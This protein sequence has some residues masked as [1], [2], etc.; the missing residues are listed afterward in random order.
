MKISC[1]IPAYNEGPRIKGVLDVVH[2]HPLVD[3]VVVVDD[4]SKDTTREIVRS[5]PRV[6]LISHSKNQG[7]SRAVMTG[8]K[9]ASHEYL[10]FL[11]A[12]LLGLDKQAV[13]K[14]IEDVASNRA[15]IAISLRANAPLPWRLIGLDYISGERVFPK[16]LITPHLEEVANLPPFGL[17]SF[18][19]NLIIKN[20]YRVKVVEWSQ[21]HSPYKYK[22]SGFLRGLRDDFFMIYDILKTISL[23]GIVS[24]IV[25]LRALKI[26]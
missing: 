23:R 3:E 22:K 19:N 24:Q 4:C 26:D 12:D 10:L 9:A 6:K 11:D 16:E 7:K 21:V 5:F 17:E 2:D 20:R 25:N 18:M 8:L 15:D 13:A 14:L 1:I